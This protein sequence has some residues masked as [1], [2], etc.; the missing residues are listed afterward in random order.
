MITFPLVWLP[1]WKDLFQQP[2]I[3]PIRMIY[4]DRLNPAINS[5]RYYSVDHV[6][7]EYVYWEQR[8]V[9]VILRTDLEILQ[10][11]TVRPKSRLY[12]AFTVS[13]AEPQSN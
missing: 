6:L 2:P 9:A 11:R 13:P 7:L 8:C 1:M 3:S 12:L 4:W 5:I 10:H